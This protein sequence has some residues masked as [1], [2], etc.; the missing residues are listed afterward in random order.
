MVTLLKIHW[1]VAELWYQGDNER[2]ENRVKDISYRLF[3]I[4]PR[5]YDM[6]KEK[7]DMSRKKYDMSIISW[8]YDIFIFS[9]YKGTYHK[10]VNLPNFRRDREKSFEQSSPAWKKYEI[11][12][13]KKNLQTS[14]PPYQSNVLKNLEWPMWQD[15]DTF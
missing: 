9:F 1:V 2:T 12:N 6:S 4:C 11:S 14:L 13:I 10:M 15:M 3:M 5:K 8:T 7:Y